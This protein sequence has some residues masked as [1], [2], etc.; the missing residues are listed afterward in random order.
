MF[1]IYGLHLEG[2]DE[3][4]YVGSTCEPAKRLRQHLHGDSKNL[5][6]DQWVSCNREK[7]RMR[8]LQSDVSERNRRS[9]EQRAI[10]ECLGKG[11]RLFNDRRA[12]RKAATTEDVTWWLDRI[13]GTIFEE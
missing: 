13:E 12:S 1:Y 11:H 5:E 8:I 7:V 6:K 9:A 2:D 4:R 3:I 10:L